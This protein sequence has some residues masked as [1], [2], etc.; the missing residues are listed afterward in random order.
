MCIFLLVTI[1][2]L[3]LLFYKQPKQTVRKKKTFGAYIPKRKVKC[4][5]CIYFNTTEKT[6]PNLGTLDEFYGVANCNC[7][8]R[9]K[10]GQVYE[11]KWGV[12][13]TDPRYHRALIQLVYSKYNTNYYT[14]V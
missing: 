1:L 10:T 13:A 9:R 7:S 6:I 5:Q 4:T 2:G 12:Y 14:E 8:I 11:H 3:G